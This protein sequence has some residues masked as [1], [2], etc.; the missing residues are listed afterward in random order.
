[1]ERF[2]FSQI[3]SATLR[4]YVSLKHRPETPDYWLTL[5]APLDA[6]D[7]ERL[8]VLA[9][10][11][12][13]L[14]LAGLNEATLWAR[15]IYPLLMLAE[16]S[17]ARTWAG[18]PL[19]AEFPAFVLE[20]TLDGVIGVSDLGDLGRPLLIV[21][22]AKRGLEA[23]DPQPQLLAEMLAVARC[24][25]EAV[26]HGPREIFGCYTISD[27]WT[28]ARARVGDFDAERPTFEVT[29]SREHAAWVEAETVLGILKGIVAHSLA[30]WAPYLDPAS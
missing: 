24:N 5:S 3:S 14:R 6:R 1:M 16:Q 2:T 27:V 29:L 13:G 9:P 30:A 11:L 20:G 25:W 19:R 21:A 23:S 10:F 4:P 18:V 7:R 12:D 15:A 17:S 22:E 26:P 28:F 8:A